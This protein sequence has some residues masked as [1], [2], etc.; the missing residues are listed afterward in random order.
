MTEQQPAGSSLTAKA[1]AALSR[2]ESVLLS[3]EPE[4]AQGLHL[5]GPGPQR[6]TVD[7]AQDPAAFDALYRAV[8]DLP[9]LDL[10]AL[11]RRLE[12][13]GPQTPAAIWQRSG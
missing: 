5:I 8:L 7:E 1:L 6:L 2:A 9:D 10:D 11:R 13:P 4:G 12:R 3:V